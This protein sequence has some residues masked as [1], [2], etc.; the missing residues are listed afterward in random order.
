[1]TLKENTH[2]IIISNHFKNIS[3]KIVDYTHHM[4]KGVGK[5][6]VV[7]FIGRGSIPLY[8]AARKMSPALGLDRS[9]TTLVQGGNFLHYFKEGKGGPLHYINEGNKMGLKAFIKKLNFK[10]KE[11]AFVVDTGIMGTEVE[12]ISK[13]IG[14]VYP[15]LKIE[16]RMIYSLNPNIKSVETIKGSSAEARV[17]FVSQRV[18]ELEN[19]PHGNQVVGYTPEGKPIYYNTKMQ[20]GEERRLSLDSNYESLKSLVE[21]LNKGMKKEQE[22]FSAILDQTVKRKIERIKNSK[23]T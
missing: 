3:S 22:L 21:R 14:E 5:K 8:I 6:E 15:H 2:N 23:R 18:N 13:I 9:N 10:G 17:K 12:A 1:M 16:K 11:R 4:L 7:L 20:R 19:W